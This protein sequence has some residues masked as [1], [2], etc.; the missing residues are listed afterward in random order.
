MNMWPSSA[1]YLFG[2]EASGLALPVS[3]LDV[4]I[5]GVGPA[6]QSAAQGFTA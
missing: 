4:V 5:L 3:D 6:M 1:T 2:S